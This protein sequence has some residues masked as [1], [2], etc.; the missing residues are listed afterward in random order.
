MGFFSYD[1]KHC[2]HPMLSEYATDPG[3]N[4]WMSKAVVIQGEDPLDHFSGTYDGYGRLGGGGDCSFDSEVWVHLACWEV[5][6]KPGASMYTGPSKSSE[7]QGYFFDD[8]DHD[9]I[10]PRITDQ[11]ERA[12]LL[13]KGQA[14]RNERRYN[15]KARQ[16]VEWKFDGP[17]DKKGKPWLSR[18]SSYEIK[19]GDEAE[20]GKFRL[21]DKWGTHCDAVENPEARAQELWEEFERTSEYAALLHRARVLRDAA[22]KQAIAEWLDK[23]DRFEVFPGKGGKLWDVYDIAG[24]KAVSPDWESKEAAEKE[25]AK[26]MNAWI[27]AGNPTPD[28]GPDPF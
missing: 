18:W 1:C 4:E 2:G 5:V 28:W 24:F 13:A 26:R 14:D 6:G 19:H 15:A 22:R 7:D 17:P 11:E 23:K 20:I 25:A 3:I 8:G 12:A 16:L 21:W 10:D 9:M 27:L